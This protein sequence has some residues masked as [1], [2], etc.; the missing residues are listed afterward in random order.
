[1]DLCSRKPV[2]YKHPSFPCVLSG[3]DNTF[4]FKYRLVSAWIGHNY[5]HSCTERYLGCFQFGTIINK[6]AKVLMCRFLMHMLSIYIY[7]YLYQCEGVAH[8]AEI[9]FQALHKHSCSRRHS[10]MLISK[11]TIN[12]RIG[13]YTRMSAVES[14]TVPAEPGMNRYEAGITG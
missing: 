7:L 11:I 3:L 5:Y 1:M 2:Q 10:R 13:I 6:P 12:Y 14:L 9:Q 8:L 4:P